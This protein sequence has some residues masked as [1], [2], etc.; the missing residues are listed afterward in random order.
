MLAKNRRTDCRLL[1]DCSTDVLLTTAKG[2]SA[3]IV[4]KEGALDFVRPLNGIRSLAVPCLSPRAHI[5][6][7]NGFKAY[8]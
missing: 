1:G 4:L 8:R 2:Q 6:Y 3:M 5:L 7:G